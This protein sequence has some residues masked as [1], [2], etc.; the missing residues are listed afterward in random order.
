MKRGISMLILGLAAGAASLT[1]NAVQAQCVIFDP[2]VLS[3]S[4]DPFNPSGTTVQTLTITARRPPAVGGK[5]TQEVDFIYLRRP[6]TPA[7]LAVV[8]TS[9]GGQILENPPGHVLDPNN[10]NPNEVELNFGGVGQPDVQTFAVT[11]TVP[12][13]ADLAAGSTDLFVDQKY[14]CKRTGGA[15]DESGVV[16]NSLDIRI[17][18]LSALQASFVGPALDFGEIGALT[19]AALPATPN[20]VKQRTGNV[21]VAS[22]GPYSVALTSANQFRMTYP[23]GNLGTANLR[24]P[25]QLDFLGQTRSN[26]SPTFSTVTCQRAGLSGQYLAISPTLLEGGAGK[27]PAPNYQ[28]ILTVTVTPLAVPPATTPVAC[29]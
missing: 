24:I 18:V 8:Q 25:Y 14:Y 12:S 17:N 21:R 13:G 3:G 23:G 9:T 27:A 10:T 1:A 26:A 28:D 5:K 4:F 19:T 6:D 29:M 22:S 20:S 16:P 11:I 15:A 2:V 7:S